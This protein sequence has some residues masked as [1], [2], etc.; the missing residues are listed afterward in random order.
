MTLRSFARVAAP[1][2]TAKRKVG[3]DPIDLLGHHLL[4]LSQTL[5]MPTRRSA[6]SFPATNA[7]EN[8]LSVCRSN[9]DST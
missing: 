2:T 5:K 6:F 3:L 4:Q 8:I 9:V 1:G 7:V